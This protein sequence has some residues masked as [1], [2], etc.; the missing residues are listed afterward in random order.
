MLIAPKRLCLESPLKSSADEIRGGRLPN[1]VALTSVTRAREAALGLDHGTATE[2][3]TCAMAI[4][5]EGSPPLA[6][7]AVIE[8]P[9]LFIDML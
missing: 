6:F 9:A 8:P 3:D 2:H 4:R 1:T 7:R 5:I